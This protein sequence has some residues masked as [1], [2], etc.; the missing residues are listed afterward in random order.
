MVLLIRLP[1]EKLFRERD[2]PEMIAI[3][4]IVRWFEEMRDICL[5]DLSIKMFARCF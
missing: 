4:Y 1:R 2:G 3:L 5:V